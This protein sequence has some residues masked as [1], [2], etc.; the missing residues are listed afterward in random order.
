M[1]NKQL[2]DVLPDAR[3][4]GKLRKPL[5]LLTDDS[6]RVIPGSCFIAVRGSSFDGHDAIPGAIAA[7]ARAIVAETPCPPERQ[8]DDLLW[9][10]VSDTHLANGLLMS[11][12]RGFPS[13]SLV[14]LG[15]T[16]TNGKTTISYLCNA[17]FRSTWQRAGLIGTIRYDDGNTRR[18]SHNT[19]PGAAEL[20]SML[21][22]MVRNGCHAC[23]IEVSSHALVQKRTAGTNF[24]VGIFTNLTQDHLDFHHSMEEYYQAKKLLFT[25]MAASG[26]R[27]ATA[28]INIDDP[29]GR[30]LAEEIA[31]LMRVRTYGCSADAD[32]RIEPKLLSL[33]GS[34][35][36]LIYQGRS[37]LVRT[38]LIGAFNISNSLAALAGTVSAG[39]SLRDAISCLAQSP[40]VPGRLE[41][42]AS[43]NNVQCF[44][45]YAHTPD[46]VENV[47][48]TMKELC[49]NG[50][51]ITIFGC[52]GDRD[53]TKRPLMGAAAA[54][55]SDLCLVTSD[56]PRSEDP[57]AIIDEIMPGI[58]RDKQHRIT[59]R[60]EAIRAALDIARPGDVV[61]IAG[62]GHEDYQIFADE[63]IHFSDA[64]VVRGYYREKNPEGRSVPS[65]R[66][67]PRPKD[68]H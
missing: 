46:A 31:P 64:E 41:L 34:Q 25:G 48:R 37:Y 27:K 22:D 18:N 50:R 44:V 47:C 49:R 58:P 45:D 32:F 9:V 62:K 26:D 60:A 38:P 67:A 2:F 16:G 42:V 17:I 68:N 7:G 28:V 56:N 24:R 23:A 30:R 12:W 14:M 59:D 1:Q 63:T 61:L 43:E 39:V 20:Q 6:R 29:Y 15:V 8:N 53:R 4:S 21:A 66:L 19:T 11:A 35:Y 40:Q 57:E 54:R 51:L 36:E 65:G 13:H 3:I 33:K 52:G 5:S 55:H 10:Q